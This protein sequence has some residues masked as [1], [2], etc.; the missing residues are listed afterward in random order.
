MKAMEILIGYMIGADI[1][2][3]VFVIVALVYLIVTAIR[4]Y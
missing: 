1:V 4:G 3:V 2:L